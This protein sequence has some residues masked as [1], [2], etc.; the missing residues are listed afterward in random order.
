[1][2]KDIEYLRAVAHDNNMKQILL[3]FAV[4]M[5]AF[6]ATAACFADYKAKRDNPLR[7]HYGVVEVTGACTVQAARAEISQRI[8]RD[9]WQLL[10]V[11]SIFGP[12]GLAERKES[13]GTYFLRF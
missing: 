3:T 5:M 9:G 7:L 13:A 8:A 11:V 10:N 1:M 6:P 4:L 2:R 12:E